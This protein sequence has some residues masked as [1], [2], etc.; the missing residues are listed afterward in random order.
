MQNRIDW[1]QNLFFVWI[2]QFLSMAAFS[3]SYTFLPFYL[4]EIGL[5]QAE[6]NWYF[7]LI[8]GLGNL[9]FAIAAPLWGV[10]ADRYGRKMMLL[11][12][13]FGAALLIPVMGLLT[14]PDWLVIH[15]IACGVVTGTIAA[16]QTLTLS[17]TPEEKRNLALGVLSSAIYSGGTIGQFLGG[18][19]VSWIGFSMTFLVSGILLGLSG[20]LVL[21]FAR[22][23]FHPVERRFCFRFEIPRFGRVW[24]LFFLFFFLC[25]SRD[26]GGL[27]TVIL[28]DEV[29][30]DHQTALRYAGYL[31]G[32]ASIAAILSGVLLGYMADRMKLLPLLVVALALGA[33]LRFP[34]GMAGDFQ[35]LLLYSCLFTFCCAGLEPLLQS[36]L[37]GVTPASEHGR[38]F[39]WAACFKAVGWSAASLFSGGVAKLCDDNVRSVFVSGG[40]LLLCAVPLTLWIAKFIS[41]PDR[42]KRADAK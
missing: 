24:M 8:C 11:R 38:Y 30:G 16:A 2:S 4:Q 23:N 26:F 33:L 27:Y 19:L 41:P 39:G 14:D 17:T 37:A 32:I 1:R 10:L 13:N 18:P 35:S 9:A 22:E 40:L 6:V 21:L 42:A 12:A 34:Q 28:V 15:R 7:A 3:S 29:M 31:S 36:W 25:V 5:N 20:V